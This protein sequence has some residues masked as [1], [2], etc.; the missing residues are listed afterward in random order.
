MIS[1]EVQ[2]I[3]LNG[4]VTMIPNEE[5]IL[6]RL[7]KEKF[8]DYSTEDLKSILPLTTN[9]TARA[10]FPTLLF[11]DIRSD[12]DTL[13]SDVEQLWRQFSFSSL[14]RDLAI[15][16]SDDEILLFSASTPDF[17]L[18]KRY[19]F[20]F[21]PATI[22][23]PLQS[24]S[25]RLTN[26]G[27]LATAF[28]IHL[29]NEK[30]L[31]LEAWCDEDEPSEELNML[32]C[33]IEEMKCFTIEP[34]HAFLE[35]GESVNVNISYTHSYLKYGGL[36]KLP[37]LVRIAQGKHFFIDLI[38]RTLISSQLQPTMQQS[39][40]QTPATA[41]SKSASSNATTRKTPA[42]SNNRNSFVE[43]PSNNIFSALEFLLW[44]PAEENC[45]IN[46]AHVPIGLNSQWAPRQR[47]E[48]FNVGGVTC[49]YEI[50]LKPLAELLD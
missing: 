41:L 36:H 26:S 3:D 33:I 19:S 16:L 2:A 42:T 8:A 46:L 34:R 9:F 25:I 38:G 40:A 13:V 11:E 12:E 14:N 20:A 47:I 49:E 48:I 50:D 10:A 23:S 15:P 1:A 27:Y 22:G 5:A 37:L 29:P 28:H 32:I 18:F 43:S 4:D 24:L 17:S 21:T 44:I 45:I 30:E 6:L 7:S 39:V 31:D 35:P